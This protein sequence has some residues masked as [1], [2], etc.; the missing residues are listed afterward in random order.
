MSEPRW[1]DGY[2]GQS[3][4]ELI[5]LDGAFR[6]DSIVLAF[7]QAINNKAARVGHRNLTPSERVVLAVE[8]LEREVN[9]DGY[10]GLFSAASEHVPELVS[11]LSAIGSDVVA[12]LTRSAIAALGIDGPLTPEAVES[13]MYDDDEGRNDRLEECDLAYYEAAGDLAPPL[14]AYIAANRDQIGLP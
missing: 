2:S 14:L 5:A 8:A 1:L 3:T 4:D 7:E 6:T 13:A 11:A 10:N 9:N 12:D